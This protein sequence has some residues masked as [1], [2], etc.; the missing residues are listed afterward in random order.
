M[1]DRLRVARASNEILTTESGET[2][3]DLF[4]G[5]GT[6]FLG[7]NN[8]AILAGLRDQL[9]R[10]WNTGILP[11][12]IRTEAQ[13]QV[14]SFFPSSHTLAGLYS[15]GMEAAEFALRFAR[16]ATGRGGLIGFDRS[17][18]GKSL[19]TAALGWW[20]DHVTLPD[21]RRLPYLPECP[22][23]EIL[24]QLAD[25]LAQKTV[26]AV[27]VEPIQGS[28]GG[29]AA[30][31]AFHQAVSRLCAGHGTLLV[32]DEILTGFHRTGGPFMFETL[33]VTPDVVLVGKA[34]GNGFP[35][36]G[37]V[38]SR[39]H[40]IEPKML[41][42]TTYAG[43][44]L[45]AAAVTATLRAMRELSL[46]SM[47]AGLEATVRAELAPVQETGA[48][49]RGR[50]ALWILEL[51]TPLDPERVAARIL[52]H[53]VLVSPMGRSIR[54]FPP[55]TISD[56]RLHQACAVIREACLS[57]ARADVAPA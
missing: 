39:R 25:A 29:H 57:S 35:V 18:H 47:V 8:P 7:H 14:E 20:N 17:M 3:V 19:A 26:A 16:V 23:S 40:P 44:P 15:T 32:F 53:R 9:D 52:Q 48:V 28:G 36:S 2:Y 6:V 38:V 54:L 46:P 13:A 37:V 50:G 55:A 10:V 43:N 41:P 1:L 5:S 22:E 27:F 42:A 45:A 11:T 4:C 56:D 24:E 51:P 49:L 34:M 33:G 12:A 31:P 30:S 21:V